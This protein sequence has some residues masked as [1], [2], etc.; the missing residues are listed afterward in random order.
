VR[1][2]L[3]LNNPVFQNEW[4]AL[5]KPEREAV[6]TACVKLSQLTWHDLY[7]DRGFR[8]EVIHSR[9]APD[10]SRLYSLRIAQN[11]RAVAQPRRRV[12]SPADAAPG[13]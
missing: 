6:L 7:R 3:D 12:S 4:F 5:E 1:I 9:R 13:P 2:R 10:G 11:V 8:W